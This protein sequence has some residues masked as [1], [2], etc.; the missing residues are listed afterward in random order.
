MIKKI[1]SATL[2]TAG[3]AVLIGASGIMCAMNTAQAQYV[4]P[5]Q[6]QTYT[7]VSQILKNPV[8]DQAFNLKGKITAKLGHERY[9]FTDKT[10]S[11]RAE[12]DDDRF[13]GVQVGPDTPIEVWGKVDTSRTKPVKIDVKRLTVIK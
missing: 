3:L 2:G 4:G 6:T 7:T 5:G 1:I 9:T 11:I 8:D 10:G 13:M 12:I